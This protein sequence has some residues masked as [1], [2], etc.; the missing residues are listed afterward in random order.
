MGAPCSGQT[1]LELAEWGGMERPIAI[2]E[3]VREGSGRQ[4]QIV[5]DLIGD[6]RGL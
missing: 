6:L 3:V 5:P 2:P 4:Y 1:I